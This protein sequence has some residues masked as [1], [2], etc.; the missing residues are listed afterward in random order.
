VLFASAP[1]VAQKVGSTAMQFLK[2]MPSARATALGEAY[3]VWASGAE[4]VSW[5][6]G[7]VS[8]VV[9]QEFSATYVDWLFDTRQGA[10][11]YALSLGDIG[12]LGVQIQY[13]DFGEFEETT[14]QRPYISDPD[15]PGITGRTF[16]PFSALVGV[17]YARNL[18]DKFSVGLGAKYVHESLYGGQTIN[19]MVT[20]GMF[21]DVTTWG[22]GVL[23]D[24]GMRYNTGFRTIQIAAAVQNFGADVTFAKESNPVPLLFRF[25]IAAD[26]MGPNALLSADEGNR[27][28]AAF[29]IFHPND[30]SQQAHLGVE[31]EFA[32]VFALRAGYK[33]NYDFEG[34]TFGGGLKHQ[35]AGVGLSL[36]YS[37][38]SMGT[39]LGSVQ[40]ISLGAV[41]P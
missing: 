8:L 6:P 2:V 3:S 1:A 38:G 32:S 20:Q 31:Y 12:A 7:G 39:Y 11:S 19:A 27:L 28:S 30:Y 4:A 34:L 29:D 35:L 24:F 18:T 15:A 22:N 10:L 23:F 13:V 5:N 9:N 36:D 40:R 21:E 17:T 25:G 16:R 14:N 33:L 26:L 37:Y 41:L